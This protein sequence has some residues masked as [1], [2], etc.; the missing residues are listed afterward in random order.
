G[1]DQVVN[2]IQQQSATGRL[3][4]RLQTSMISKKVLT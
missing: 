1:P 4:P 3:K 2:F